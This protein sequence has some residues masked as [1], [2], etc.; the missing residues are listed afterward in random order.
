MI[1]KLRG[2]IESWMEDRAIIDVSGVGY[3]VFASSKTL[4][5]IRDP[6][7]EVVLF[8]E[9]HVR[10]DHIH[11]YAFADNEEQEWF[12]TLTTVQ[13]VGAKVGLAILSALSPDELSQAV[14]SQ[15]K[16]M[17]TRASG[18]GPKLA[19]RIVSE[20]KD[21]MPK[22]SSAT[23]TYSVKSDANDVGIDALSALVNLGYKKAE[24]EMALR[25]AMDKGNDNLNDLIRAGLKE[26]A[27]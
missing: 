1:G 3:L 25:R 2:K 21:K 18:V 17:L 24:A 4:D 8:V 12:R 11:L 10:E 16:T 9:T 27:R 26:L 22:G 15:D 7:G 13:G 5:K 14:L 6:S 20:L 19:A 23:F